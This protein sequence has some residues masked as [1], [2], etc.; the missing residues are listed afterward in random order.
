MKASNKMS[1]KHHLIVF[2]LLLFVSCHSDRKLG[3]LDSQF[4]PD[5]SYVIF[6]YYYGGSYAFGDGDYGFKIATKGQEFNDSL[7]D[8]PGNVIEWSSNNRIKIMDFEDAIDGKES[9]TKKIEKFSINNLNVVKEVYKINH[10]ESGKYIFK[11][12]TQTKDSVCFAIIR[13]EYGNPKYELKSFR[14]G[15]ITIKSEADT[16]SQIDIRKVIKE[17]SR[18]IMYDYHFVPDHKILTSELQSYGIFKRIVQ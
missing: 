12:I 4:S 6:N 3:F 15:P 17:N 2:V 5:S 9:V 1:K 11:T 13:T 16:I 10:F 8:L 7:P 18:T 14:K